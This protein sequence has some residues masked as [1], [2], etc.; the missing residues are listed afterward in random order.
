MLTFMCRFGLFGTNILIIN[1]HLSAGEESSREI[2]RMEELNRILVAH[3]INKNRYDTVYLAG[4]NFIKFT[5][6]MRISYFFPA[7]YA[8]AMNQQ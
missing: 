2:Q 6:K 8:Y 1:A 3:E 4:F 7:Q 5:F